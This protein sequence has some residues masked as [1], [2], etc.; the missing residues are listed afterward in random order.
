MKSIILSFL[1]FLTVSSGSFAQETL[2][3]WE[4][5]SDGVITYKT[6]MKRIDTSQVR[7]IMKN[8]PQIE[9]ADFTTVLRTGTDNS[10]D[11]EIRQGDIE[12]SNSNS[13][14]PLDTLKML[15]NTLGRTQLKGKIDKFG[16]V[17]SFWL[18]QTQKN[19]ISLLF[20]LPSKPV[21]IGDT[22][23][24]NNI[25]LLTLNGPYEVTESSQIN[26]VTFREVTDADG[27]RV[28]VFEYEITESVS[29]EFGLLKFEFIGTGRFDME[30]NKWFDF[31][32]VMKTVNNLMGSMTS[33]QQFSLQ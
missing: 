4:V 8:F 32:G 27:S 3:E 13:E 26:E 22:W 7:G 18:A 21:Q 29:G 31:N 10:I 5:P 33:A 20:Q 9:S 19:L 6:V 11:V 15:M 23:S 12:L 2:F 24:L 28:A 16:S 17:K 14:I 30:R 25:S 1:L